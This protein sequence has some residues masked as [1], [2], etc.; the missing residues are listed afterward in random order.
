[1]VKQLAV[2]SCANQR[3]ERERRGLAVQ[4]VTFSFHLLGQ[5]Y[6]VTDYFRREMFSRR[7]LPGWQRR[8]INVITKPITFPTWRLSYYE[9]R[10]RERDPTAIGVHITCRKTPA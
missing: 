5:I 10:L 9:D 8:L 3:D 2:D 6:D 4:V 7:N 1:M